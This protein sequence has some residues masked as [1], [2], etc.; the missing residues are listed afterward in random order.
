MRFCQ[1][2]KAKGVPAPKAALLGV[3]LAAGLATYQQFLIRF[4]EP[5]ACFAAFLNNNWLGG[6]VFLGLAVDY[7]LQQGG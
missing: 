4:R 3:A 7:W 1:F 2:Y 6:A 5:R